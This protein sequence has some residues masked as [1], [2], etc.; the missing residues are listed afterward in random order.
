MSDRVTIAG[1]LA[2]RPGVG[3]H[4]AVFVHWLRG[5]RRLGWDVL[6]VDRLDPSSD[7]SAQERWLADVMEAAGIGDRWAALGPDGACAGRPRAEVLE[8]LRGSALLLNVMGY[9]DDPDLLAAAPRRVFLD[10]D[11]GFPQMWRA[12][13]L[14]DAFAGHDD[15]V[16]V[17]TRVGLP[18]S[19]VPTCGLDWIHTLPPVDLEHWPAGRDAP[20]GA[21]TSIAT[22]R[23]PFG[24]VDF[25]G[26]RYG[27][28]VHEFRRFL[29]LPSR[30]G[31]ALEVA[32]SIDSGDAADRDAVAGAGWV[33]ADPRAVAA[34]LS[35]YRAY[36]ER[37]AA[38]L[39]IAKQMYVDTCGG[40]FS[41]RSAC[42]LAAGRPVVAQ[43]TGFGDALPV[44]EG[45]LRFATADEAT[46]AVDEVRAG[47][48]AHAR[49]ARALA[50]EHL[51]APRVV[52]RLLSNL[53]TK[54]PR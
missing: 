23:G 47:W 41:D 12:L 29:D 26:H 21:F 22:W 11:P 36:I 46:D 31:V 20:N 35:A 14:H 27:L 45:L 39:S 33:L 7:A 19:T 8:H 1:A 50:E 28:R 18:G 51:D 48:H 3:G 54:G 13:G 32:L 34:D 53:T 38:E 25:A 10:L 5:F 42:Y 2:Q 44:G 49:A 37:S 6:F 15:V 9:L 17:G 24:P 30:T 16:T 40:W 43:D 52:E 4:A